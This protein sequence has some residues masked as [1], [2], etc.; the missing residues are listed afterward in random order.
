MKI[1]LRK[2]LFDYKGLRKLKGWLGMAV[3]TYNPSNCESEAILCDYGP[4]FNK[5]QAE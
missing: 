1:C 2:K 3:Y 5:Y 4:A